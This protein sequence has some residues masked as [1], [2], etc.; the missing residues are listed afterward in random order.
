MP[1]ASKAAQFFVDRDYS[2]SSITLDEGFYNVHRLEEAG[3]VG[4]DA[5]SSL[6][7]TEGYR[8]AVYTDADFQGAEK[9]FT[10]DAPWVGADFDEKISSIVITKVGSPF[11][12]PAVGFVVVPGGPPEV[13]LVPGGGSGFP[14]VHVM[15]RG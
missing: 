11:P 15:N 1:P 10:A 7:V 9:Q 3:S 13:E 2:G 5:I 8:V 12:A 14:G 4:N 6:K